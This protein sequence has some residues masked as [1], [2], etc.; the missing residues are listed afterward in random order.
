MD[1]NCDDAWD[2][3][4]SNSACQMLNF[5]NNSS[6]EKV[7]LNSKIPKCSELYISTTTKISYL[8]SLIDI[9]KCFWQIPIIPFTTTS[10]GVIKKQM[11]YTFKTEEEVQL[12]ENKLKYYPYYNLQQLSYVNNKD[13]NIYKDIRK[14]NIGICE[15]DIISYRCRKK[16]AFYNCFVLIFRVQDE[17]DES[18]FK[19]AHVKVFNTGKLELPGI[20]SDKSHQQII[21][22]LIAIF[23]E[24]CGLN[25]ICKNEHETVLINSNFTCG[26]CLNR[27]I[28]TNILKTQYNIHTSYDPCSYPGIR[29]Q[30]YVNGK[31]ISFMIFRTGS[32]LIVGK[33]ELIDIYCLY[34]QIK[35]IFY[36][37]YSNIV[38]NDSY[39]KISSVKHKKTRKKIMLISK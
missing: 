28:F 25:I 15:K 16:S 30:I 36:K 3:F 12:I 17:I 29:S 23:S 9:N 19:E 33:C 37:E 24:Y 7:L 6:N 39:I 4:C 27:E 35:D 34:N 2:S 5:D 21:N 38:V 18:K 8:S 26:F 31:K 20:K 1:Y 13:K 11:K 10:V 32:V 22:C 14:I